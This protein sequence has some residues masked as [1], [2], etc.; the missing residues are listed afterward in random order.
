MKYPSVVPHD[1]SLEAFRVQLECYRQMSPEQRLEQALQW[2]EEVRELGRAGIRLRHP[3]YSERE[4]QLASI[5]LRLGDE[6]FAQV[7][8]SVDVVP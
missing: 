8:P 7:Y 5:R 2:S 4:I 1:T 6:L 3:D